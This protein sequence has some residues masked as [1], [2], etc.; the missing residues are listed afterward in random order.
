MRFQHLKL[1]RKLSTSAERKF[2]E[3]L[4]DLH[5]PFRTKIKINERE[6]D[7][8][9]GKYTIDI[10]GHLQDGAKNKMLV[11]SGYIPLHISNNT[12]ETTSLDFL[13]EYVKLH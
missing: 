8:I 11:E 2:A 10:D 9:V 12:V 1:M 13:K 6:V 7:F 3:R 4:K 5:I